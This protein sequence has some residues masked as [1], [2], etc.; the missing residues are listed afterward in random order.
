MDRR[1][2]LPSDW[3]CCPSPGASAVT[4]RAL[5]LWSTTSPTCGLDCRTIWPKLPRRRWRRPD[6][7]AS[8]RKGASSD[9]SL[10]RGV[11]ARQTRYPCDQDLEED[12]EHIVAW[13]DEDMA[14]SLRGLQMG[15]CYET[16]GNVI[17]F[18]AGSYSGY[19]KWRD[20]LARRALDLPAATVWEDPSRFVEAPFFELINFSDCEGTIGP[21]AAS[22]LATDFGALRDRIAGQPLADPQEEAGSSMSMTSFKRRSSSPLAGA[23]WCSSAEADVRP[24]LALL[25]RPARRTT[26]GLEHRVSE[27]EHPETERPGVDSRIE[28]PYVRPPGDAGLRA[29]SRGR[30]GG[31]GGGATIG[32]P[33]RRSSVAT[34]RL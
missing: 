22:D 12:D 33:T 24:A 32:G 11:R 31:S 29:A 7:A 16:S 26:Q 9:G 28:R 6:R 8:D 19:N 15:R 18:R 25:H 20:E 4:A 17:E 13:V 10:H 3:T 21:D 30:C 34:S 5:A 1:R 14:R 27:V 23:G 2:D